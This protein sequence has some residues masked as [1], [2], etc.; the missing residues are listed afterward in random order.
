MDFMMLGTTGGYQNPENPRAF[1]HVTLVR[2]ADEPVITHLRLDGILDKK[3]NIPLG[4]DTINFQASK[5]VE[6]NGGVE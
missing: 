4:G 2:M 5:R 1:D 6:I 3:G